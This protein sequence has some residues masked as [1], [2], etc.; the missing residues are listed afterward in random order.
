[1]QLLAKLQRGYVEPPESSVETTAS[2]IEA[3]EIEPPKTTSR[4]RA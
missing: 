1:M 4:R 3:A 2:L